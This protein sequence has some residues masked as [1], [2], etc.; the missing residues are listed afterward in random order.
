MGILNV[1]PDSFSDGGRFITEAAIREQAA[2]MIAAGADIIDIGGESTR[3]FAPEVELGEELRRVLPAIAAVRE[4]DPEI[5]ISIDTTKAAVAKE[6]LAAGA[7]IINDI[8]A[9][10]HDPAMVELAA[11]GQWPV[12]IMHMQGTPGDMQ[13]DPSYK[14]VVGEIKEFLSR[15]V[16][17][18]AARGIEPER[19]ILDPGIGFG[20]TLEHNLEILRRL[21]EF[22]ELGRPLLLGHSRKSFLAKVL[23][24]MPMGERD[25]PSAVV[26]ALCAG[27][28][29]DIIRCH[30]VLS[31]HRA[32]SLA[33][34]LQER[35]RG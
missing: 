28:G 8:S 15:R 34:A 11:E 7:D 16:E 31:T 3:P 12:I 33:A 30:D 17:E 14:D 24:D 10:G 21:A 2:S 1:T 23:G 9:L 20:K 26:T 25:L 13:L 27:R 32:L 5:P 35:H 4:L 19:L 22:K 18:L 6:A 29:V